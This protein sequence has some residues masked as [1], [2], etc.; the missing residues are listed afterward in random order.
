MYDVLFQTGA[1]LRQQERLVVVQM[2]ERMY[3]ILALLLLMLL[4]TYLYHLL[5]LADSY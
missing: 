1:I 4:E 2:G 3:G 5:H